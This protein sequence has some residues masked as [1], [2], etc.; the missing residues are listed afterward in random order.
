MKKNYPNHF[1]SAVL[2]KKNKILIRKIKPKFQLKKGQVLV[3]VLYSGICRSQL[4]EFH[5]KRGKDRWLPHLFGHEGSGIVIAVGSGVT[6]VKIGSEVIIGWISSS[7]KQSE[8]PTYIDQENGKIINSGASSTLTNF[9][10]VSENKLIKKPKFLSFK[11]SVL[12]GCALPTG[13]GIVIKSLKKE[14]L[15]KNILISGFGG[16]GISSG[17]ALKGM[18]FKNI[19]VID[20]NLVKLKLAKK[21]FN[22]KTFQIDDDLNFNSLK[23]INQSPEICIETSGSIKALQFSFDILKKNGRL[24]FASHPPD[25]QYLKIKP[26]DLISGKRIEGSWGGGIDPEKD[27]KKMTQLIIK[28]KIK[29]IDLLTK[30]YQLNE[31]VKAFN[32]FENDNLYRPIIKMYHD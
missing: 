4:M 11:E 19:V 10:I 16:I 28:S 18:G 30:E 20:K 23:L 2:V 27:I 26:H 21:I 32:D 17:I 5:Q 9:T 1:T 24:I 8:N 14:N 12:F 25:H 13:M 3:K 15:D 6:K 29:V 22:F 7:G 31:I